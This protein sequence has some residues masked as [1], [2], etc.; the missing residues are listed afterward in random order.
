TPTWAKSAFWPASDMSCTELRVPEA[1]RPRAWIRRLMPSDR[2]HTTTAFPL[3]STATWGS[4]AFWPAGDRACT[5]LRVPEAERPRAWIRRLVPS[6]RVHTTTAFPPASTA[7][8][9]SKASW[10]AGDRVC[11]ALRVP[12]A[13]RPRAWIR[14][15]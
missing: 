2:G 10:P 13:E 4:M 14:R 8:W 7:T 11:T 3:A 1:E 5:A 15:L 6:D 9:G 12:E